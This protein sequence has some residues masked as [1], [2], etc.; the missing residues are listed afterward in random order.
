[1]LER[2]ADEIVGV[3]RGVLGCYD[4]LVLSG[5]LTAIAHPVAMAG[6]LRRAGICCFDL[7]QYVEPIREQIRQ[8]ADRAAARPRAHPV[9]DGNVHHL[10]TLARQS[11]RAD[12]REV[13]VRQVSALLFRLP[14]SGTGLRYVRVPTWIPYG[15]QVYFNGHHWLA[16]RLQQARL[17]YRMD[18]TA[19][20]EIRDWSRAQELS[21]D[22]S[23]LGLHQKLRSATTRPKVSAARRSSS[24]IRR[25]ACRSLKR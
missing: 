20:V 24:W 16:S 5:T 22:F 17:D 13:Q 19:F 2:Y 15:L 4:R 8:N 11:H 10:S 6:V 12:R 23:V 21:D 1:M 9:R 14:R 18:D 7:E 25:R 3:P